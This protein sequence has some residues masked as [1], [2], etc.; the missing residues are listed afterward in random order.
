MKI[1]L[2]V[3]P[4]LIIGITVYLSDKKER[5]PLIE[6]L[7]AFILGGI[8]ILITLGISFVFNIGTIDLDNSNML[9]IFIYSF[10]G[11]ALIEEFS[12]FLCGYLFIRK[13]PN[14]DYMYDGI[15]YFV[16]VSLGFATIEN[17]IYAFNSDIETILMRAITTVPSHAFFGMACG[18]LFAIHRREKFKEKQKKTYKYLVLSLIIPIIL[19][20]FYDFCLLEE[21]MLFFMIYVFFVVSLYSFSIGNAKKM[22]TIDHKLNSKSI[23][24]RNCGKRVKG[25]V[26]KNCGK[27]IEE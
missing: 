7:K 24:C 12:K 25:K 6:I 14:F 10:I 1:I 26:C 8:S 27:E 20:G 23:H 3:I 4:S 17:I 18:Y 22:E 16:F 13:N 21:N 11:I 19:H 2:A 9:D 5:E 15:V